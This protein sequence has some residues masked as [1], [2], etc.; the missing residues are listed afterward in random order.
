MNFFDIFWN[1]WKVRTSIK[2]Q[3]KIEGAIENGKKQ[4]EL[5]SNMP[6]IVKELY[7]NNLHFGSFLEKQRTL[8]KIEKELAK[9]PSMQDVEDEEKEKIKMELLR[10]KEFL[11]QK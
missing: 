5:N 6:E 8:I 3:Q 10:I 2:I 9:L 4:S 1:T 7:Q 11:N